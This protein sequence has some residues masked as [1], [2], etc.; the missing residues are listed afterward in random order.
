M[1]PAVMPLLAVDRGDPGIVVKQL[2]PPME[3]RT[4]IV[5]VP[6]GATPMP[7]ADRLIR[8]AKTAGRKRLARAPQ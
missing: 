1:G 5:A 6:K 2:E 8:I 3:P 7:A 4:I